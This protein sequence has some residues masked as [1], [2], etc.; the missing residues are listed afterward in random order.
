MEVG[1]RAIRLVVGEPH[2]AY[3]AVKGSNRYPPRWYCVLRDGEDIGHVIRWNTRNT[4]WRVDLLSD[5]TPAIEDRT[6]STRAAA[7][8]YIA[9]SRNG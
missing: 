4:E 9:R 3:G 6:F 7:V 1:G 5:F 2:S 8:E